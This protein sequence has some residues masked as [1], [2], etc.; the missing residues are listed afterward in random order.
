MLDFMR[1][2][3]QSP[4]LQATIVVIILVFVF[5][6]VGS[7]QGNGPN[8][9]A[10]VN[11]E[12]I[13]YQEFYQQY[14]RT[15]SQYRQQFGGSVP[16]ELLKNFGIKENVLDQLVQGVLLRQGAVAMGLGVSKDEIREKIQNIPAFQKDGQFIVSQYRE[17]LAANRLSASD[18]E[19]QIKSEIL[20]KKLI[21]H[22]QRFAVTIP[23]ELES[24]FNFNNEQIKIDYAVF[25]ADS[26]EEKVIVKDEKL[27]E[28][29]TKHEQKY[30]TDPLVSLKYLSFLYKNAAEQGSISDEKIRK[31]Y[32]KNIEKYSTP[33]KRQARHIL[34][35]TDGLKEPEDIK[36]K[37]KEALELLRKIN[38]DE[39]FAKLAQEF[40]D[41]YGSAANGGDLGLFGKGQM[42]KPFENSVFS[43]NIGQV[44]GLVK[45]RYGFHIIKLENIEP[46]NVKPLAEVR[47]EI[48]NKI[49]AKEQKNI[50]EKLARN[51]Y[52]N[53]IRSGSL[54][55]YA[56]SLGKDSNIEIKES[57]FFSREKP[58]EDFK[59]E[60]T[61]LSAAFSLKKGE[62][63]SLVQGKNGFVIIFAQDLK[64]SET[65]PLDDVREK[66]EKDFV[67]EQSLEMAKGAAD[68]MLK[69]VAGGKGFKEEAQNNGIEVISTDYLKRNDTSKLSASV[70]ASG[71]K[72]T[73]SKSIPDEVINEGRDFYLVNFVERKTPEK[74][75]FEEKEFELKAELIEENKSNL[76]AAWI[77][78]RK[79][80][81]EILINKEYLK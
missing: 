31:N 23:F 69:A 48:E 42:V 70:V 74:S 80:S 65:P 26:F 11:G 35:K 30:Q 79:Q 38:S 15:V 77:A 55:K 62:L 59:D 1:R 58:V 8:I 14:D 21:D 4:S 81:S 78:N 29:F 24:R 10:T 61:I 72:L 41:D 44:S 19:E 76:L 68:K 33:E 60:P 47:T 63:S 46:A 16:E 40:S 34:L 71:F 13:D 57:D 66:V 43:L 56:A 18:F 45:T 64:E 73:P 39:D 36:N 75:E 54:D 49:K 9:V 25:K 37:E 52:E 6:G 12:S 28:Y 32:E 53:I 27:K 67:K 51:Q 3:A 5:W 17:T 20:S 22:L 2:K 50:T 7:N